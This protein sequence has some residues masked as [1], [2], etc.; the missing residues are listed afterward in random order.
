MTTWTYPAR[1]VRVVD[2]DTVVLDIDLGMKTWRLGERCR[3]AGINAPEIGTNEGLMARVFVD[4]M[5]AATSRNVTFTSHSLDKYGR[6]LGSV[7]LADGRI[8]NALILDAGH[9]VPM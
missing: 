2:A 4:E 8:L 1:V 6:P 5:L 7:R 9:A 3:L